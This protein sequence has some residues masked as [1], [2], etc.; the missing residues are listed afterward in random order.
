M[1]TPTRFILVCLIVPLT[2]AWPARGA[3]PATTATTRASLLP[4]PTHITLKL[5]HTPVIDA[6]GQLF[7]Q[8]K[9]PPRGIS[10]PY[11][12]RQMKGVTV[13]ASIEDQPYCMALLEL[14]KRGLLEPQ[15]H[16][17]AAMR[18]MLVNRRGPPGK[19][20][21][22]WVDAPTVVSGPFVFVVREA[23]RT[24]RVQLDGENV[25]PVRDLQLNILAL[26]DLKLRPFTLAEA[27]EVEAARDEQGRS[28]RIEGDNPE[29]FA[30]RATGMRPTDFWPVTATLAYP[31]AP[32]SRSLALL[33]G[34]LNAV[35]VTRAEPIE[36][37]NNG[38]A[39]GGDKK[40]GE[41]RFTVGKLEE[42]GNGS[43]LQLIVEYAQSGQ[44]NPWDEIRTLVAA[45]GFRAIDPAGAPYAI[46]VNI[47][48]YRDNRFEG[49]LQFH[50][51]MAQRTGPRPPKIPATVA[52]DVPVEVQDASVPVEFKDLPLP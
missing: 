51:A 2:L 44:A 49:W 31:P 33:R 21:P 20:R 10:D 16:P 9:I 23:R 14:C 18:L 42:T 17:N 41:I 24:S 30:A 29:R 50:P 13:T 27:L 52:W 7:E 15:A 45:E 6:L 40:A 28:L 48:S 25:A 12:V 26:R 36:I 38:A 47:Y 46:E 3:A 39:A 35:I 32:A 43:R 5:D 22:S 34:R 19:P 4:E 1:L 11:F 37:I 8:A